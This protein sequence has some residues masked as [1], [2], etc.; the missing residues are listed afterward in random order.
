M[1]IESLLVNAVRVAVL[2]GLALVAMPILRRSS[3]ATR[4]LVLALALGGALVLPLVSAMAPAW[5]VEAP[6]A[7]T[8]LRGV[9]V[10]EPVLTAERA[11]SAPT[12]PSVPAATA[13]RAEVSPWLHPVALLIGV[14]SL[15]AALVLARLLAGI[16]RTRALVRRATPATT[17]SLASAR[18]ERSTGLRVAVKT[19][20][21]LDAPAVTGVLAPMILVPRASASWS[22]DRRYAVL[23]HE[24]AHVRQRDCLAQVVGQLACAVHWFDPL[25]WMVARRLRLERE[26]A[27]DDAV[28]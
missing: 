12:G 3:S 21:E 16:L 9:V 23:L 8:S 13:P 6:S 14:W 20:D 28:V 19:T 24:L 1:L 18:A 15:G 4:R 5:H 26:L 10:A 27:A 25:A 7:V 2:L 22:D 11:A 17:W